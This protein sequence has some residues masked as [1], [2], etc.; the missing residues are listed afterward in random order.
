MEFT[1]PQPF[2]ADERR[3][4]RRHRGGGNK[5]KTLFVRH[6]QLASV[7]FALALE[8]GERAAVARLLQSQHLAPEGLDA[9]PIACPSCLPE[10]DAAYRAECG[11]RRPGG[12]C[13]FVHVSLER[14]TRHEVHERSSRAVQGA[15]GPLHPRITVTGTPEA[16][17]VRVRVAMPNLPEQTEEVRPSTCLVTQASILPRSSDAATSQVSPLSHAVPCKIHAESADAEQGQGDAIDSDG[18]DSSD[19]SKN[20]S[21]DQLSHCVHWLQRGVCVYGGECRFVHC[22]ELSA[23]AME[24]GRQ[25]NLRMNPAPK[26]T[27]S[28]RNGNPLVRPPPVPKSV[29]TVSDPTAALA[30]GVTPGGLAPSLQGPNPVFLHQSA[31][32][33]APIPPV[34]QGHAPAVLVLANPGSASPHAA[35]NSIQ[36][37]L[38]APPQPHHHQHSLP[39]QPPGEPFHLLACPSLHGPLMAAPQPLPYP[40]P[41]PHQHQHQHQHHH[42]HPYQHPYPQYPPVHGQPGGGAPPPFIGIQMQLPPGEAPAVPLGDAACGFQIPPG[43]VYLSQAPRSTGGNVPHS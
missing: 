33:N 3:S 26:H 1:Q 19:S 23:E 15:F 35:H 34:P 27:S 30:P 37:A 7:A 18:G 20:P 10:S 9:L 13:V 29:S 24:I 32:W 14:A 42:Q 5:R 39:R 40:H 11:L 21:A 16:A 28:A 25:R 41:H 4:V 38:Q 22:L 17:E 12:R 2:Q 36:V 8:S 43:A 31:P 6:P